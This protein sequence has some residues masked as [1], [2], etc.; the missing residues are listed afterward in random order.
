MTKQKHYVQKESSRFLLLRKSSCFFFG[1]LNL[2][3]GIISLSSLSV[4]DYDSNHE[5]KPVYVQ[6]CEDC[7]E[8]CHRPS[9]HLAFQPELS[10]ERP[11]T[12]QSVNDW[13]E[14]DG[15]E[16]EPQE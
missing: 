11:V 16:V 12:V 6:K 15:T 1:E 2:V 3:D 10:R 5:V 14:A 4:M 7:Q 13:D 8:T 9:N